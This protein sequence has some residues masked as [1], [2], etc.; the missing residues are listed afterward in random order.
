[1][2]ECMSGRSD[3][4]SDWNRVLE[5]TDAD[6][7]DPW[8]TGSDWALSAQLAFNP[9]ADVISEIDATSGFAFATVPEAVPHGGALVPLEPMWLFGAPVIGID[10]VLAAKRATELLATRSE[11]SIYLGGYVEDSPWWHAL[12]DAFGATCQLFGGEERERCRASFEG[13]VDGYLSRRTRAFR[14][15]LRQ[16]ERRAANAGVSFEVIDQQ[17]PEATLARLHRI[18]QQSWKGLDGS[19]I[20]GPDMATLYAR[21]VPQLHT[22]NALRVCVAIDGDG[23]DVGFVFGGVRNG[24][25]RGL[26]LSFTESARA[27]GVGNMLQWHEIQRLCNE[28]LHTY[29]IG[30][31][32]E[33]KRLWTENLFTTRLLIAQR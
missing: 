32:M 16:G 33:Y 13:G 12:I 26:Q 31:D 4:A 3:W 9:Q 7:I 6:S 15:N 29:D 22:R 2:L 28:N 14:R 5:L 30:M 20:E 27:L 17:T 24:T 19:G 23:N 25:Y 8:C 1:M 18:E 11:R 10:P 21:L